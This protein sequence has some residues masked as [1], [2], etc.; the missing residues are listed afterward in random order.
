MSTGRSATSGYADLLV[1]V[2]STAASAGVVLA[3]DPGRW[4]ALLWL[5]GVPLLVVFPGYAIVSAM[6]PTRPTGRWPRQSTVP[7]S[8]DWTVRIALTIVGSTIVVG[9]LGVVLDWTVGIDLVAAVVGICVVTLCGTAIA[10]IRRSRQPPTRRAAPLSGAFGRLRGT[11]LNRQHMVLGLAIL[12]LVGAVAFVGATPQQGETFTESYLLTEGPDGEFLADEYP[13]TVTAG[14]TQPLALGVENHEHREMSYEV[15]VVLQNV[16]DD[17]SVANQQELDRFEIELGHGEGTVV[18]RD[19]TPTM[20]GE[21]L[22][23][24]FLV[25]KGGEEATAADQT[26]QLWIDVVRDTDIDTES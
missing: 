11:N 24:R 23:L 22:R 3:L 17:G 4:Q 13:T 1:L 16:R 12:A 25:Y 18:E 21:G 5:F 15:V 8:P 19:L 26:L 20:T 7:D 10:A 6:F 14:E 2:V 9:V